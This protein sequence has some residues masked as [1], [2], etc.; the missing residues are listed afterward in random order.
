MIMRHQIEIILGD[1]LRYLAIK[2]RENLGLTQR[3][4][5]EHLQ[6]SESSYSDIETGK[7][8]CSTVTAVLLLA[9][10]KDPEAFLSSV[11]AKIDK[12]FRTEA[13]SV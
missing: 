11:E 1:E 6:M 9:M 2:T 7:S 10:Q 13:V 5:S 12:V 4:M 3:K 8:R